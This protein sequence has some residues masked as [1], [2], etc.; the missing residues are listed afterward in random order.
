MRRSACGQDQQ[1]QQSLST[2]PERFTIEHSTTASRPSEDT[3]VSTASSATLVE[4]PQNTAPQTRGATMS[5]GEDG[6]LERQVSHGIGGAG[7]IRKR[8]LS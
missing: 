4:P 2:V 8:C 7:N 5:H 6:S 1:Q 3:L